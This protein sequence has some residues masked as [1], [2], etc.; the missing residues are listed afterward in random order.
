[1]T[2]EFGLS[3][4][5]AGA[6]LGTKGFVDII[7]GLAGSILVDVIG[8]RRISIIAMSIA[9]IGRTLL[10]FGRS[11]VSL[12]LAL[13]LFSPCGDALLSTGLYRVA[14]KKLTT[15]YT[16]PLAFA[17]S[18]AVSNLAGALADVCVD[19]MRSSLKDVQIEEGGYL[20]GVY[21]PMRQFIVVTW[22]IVLVT[23]VIAY[24]FLEDWTVID[25]NDL[26]DDEKRKQSSQATTLQ[27][28]DN[29]S[30]SS[31]I[32]MENETDEDDDD[33]DDDATTSIIPIDALPASPMIRPNI[34]QNWFPNQY[35]SMHA[36]EDELQLEVTDDEENDF[37]T[38][39]ISTA[40]RRSLPKYQMYRT[41]YNNN[42]D[43]RE[44]SSCS[45]LIQL[46][47]QVIA[48]LKL[49]NTWRVLIFG[50]LSF[51]IVLDWTASELVLPPF[52]ERRFGEK[53]PIYTIQSIN[54]FGCLILP[55]FVG[56]LTT[57]REDFQIVMPG[58][59]L[60]ALS[61]IFVALY[62]NVWGS[63]AWQVFMTI[64]EV[65]WSPRIISWTASLAPTGMEGLFFAVSSARAILGPLTDMVMGAM[66]DKYNTN[67]P[68][69]RDQYGHFCD[70]AVVNDDNNANAAAQ[71]GSVQEE[72]NLFLDNQQQQQS[73]PQTCLECPS[74][75]PTNPSTFWYLLM[76]AGIA[77]PLAVWLFLPFL[78]GVRVR[79]DKCYGLF[80]VNKARML[81]ICGAQDDD[82]QESNI[83]RR[84]G[85][86]VY[87]HLETNSSSSSTSA[88]MA[89][90]MDINIELT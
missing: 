58:L 64:G 15:P 90:G 51:T 67:C 44:R 2:N 53:I 38:L 23:F 54:L 18:Y 47:N 21:T 52:L 24:C 69:C 19:K 60:M 42:N 17:V 77:A 88:V 45:G 82:D 83:R 28:N 32:M 84:Q 35:D 78:R 36:I 33:D 29:Q 14:L 9:I 50:F 31:I 46:V 27:R 11:S 70:T 25:P 68:D 75:V 65:L 41:R 12:Y 43:T 59:W 22:V 26:D 7:F 61:P 20:S 37:S 74:W 62:P 79:D 80:R 76:I 34:L 30:S 6:L 86:Q 73:C 13:F 72:C 71:C 66:N 56:A 39:A 5:H 63:C 48:I 57:G 85:R 10:A 49:R 3:D 8:V 4:V 16:R 1:M 81:G 89:N 55:P 87:G 40:T